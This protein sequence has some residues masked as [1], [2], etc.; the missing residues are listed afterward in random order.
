MIDSLLDVGRFAVTDLAEP[1]GVAVLSSLTTVKAIKS[2][3]AR[4]E[5][6]DHDRRAAELNEDLRRWVRDRD[7][8]ASVRMSEITQQAAANG[9]RHGGTLIAAAGKVYRHALHEYRD[10][11][12]DKQRELDALLDAEGN[13][14]ARRRRR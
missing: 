4:G 10:V 11:A 5:V 1:V 13:T 14:H 8:E 3:S 9:V 7:R 2:R 6:A 12:T